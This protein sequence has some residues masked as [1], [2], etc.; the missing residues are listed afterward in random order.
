[1]RVERDGGEFCFPKYTARKLARARGRRTLHVLDEGTALV[2]RAKAVAFDVLEAAVKV[3]RCREQ[4]L[5]KRRCS[6]RSA[7]S[8]LSGA[9]CPRSRSGE[10]RDGA[11]ARA[12]D[13]TPSA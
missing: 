8:E 5:N 2:E 12:H 3:C 4:G 10:A 11:R 13:G 6:S 9:K 1:M 7:V